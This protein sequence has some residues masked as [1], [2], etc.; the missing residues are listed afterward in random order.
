MLALLRINGLGLQLLVL[1]VPFA[2]AA[3][4]DADVR[5]LNAT[6]VSA[7]VDASCPPLDFLKNHTKIIDGSITNEGGAVLALTEEVTLSFN[8]EYQLLSDNG[9][10]VAKRVN[11]YFWKS[12]ATIY[13][14]HD[15][16][17]F[18][19]QWKWSMRAAMGSPETM[20]IMDRFGDHVGDWKAPTGASPGVIEDLSGNKVVQFTIGTKKVL[21]VYPLVESVSIELFPPFDSWSPDLTETRL[22][23]LLAAGVISPAPVGPVWRWILLAVM[24]LICLDCFY[25]CCKRFCGH[26]GAE[27]IGYTDLEAAERRKMEAGLDVASRAT[28]LQSAQSSAVGELPVRDLQRQGPSEQPKPWTMEWLFCCAR[29]GTPQQQTVEMVSDQNSQ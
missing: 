22:L 3:L 2:S 15:K 12:L 4:P 28:P 25:L 16:K 24:A 26:A 29:G 13:N 11:P 18:E 17:I 8:P 21:G 10:L 7:P 9:M 1:A 20:G 5:R 19:L 6:N 14:C 23:S 27:N